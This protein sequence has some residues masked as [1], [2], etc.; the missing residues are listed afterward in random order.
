M[1]YR[2]FI[3]QKQTIINEFVKTVRPLEEAVSRVKSEF[4]AKLQK[5]RKEYLD[6]YLIDCEG[7]V[8]K[9]ND[10]LKL[11]SKL[12]VVLDRREQLLNGYE[13]H[14]PQVRCSKVNKRGFLT[15]T[16]VFDEKQCASAKIVSSSEDNIIDMNLLKNK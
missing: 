12:Y 3:Q 2:E 9:E 6:E 10:V 8:I 5:I 7:K 16:I 4:D 13:T 11:E 1:K 14:N 15:T